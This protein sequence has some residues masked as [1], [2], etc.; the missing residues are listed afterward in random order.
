MLRPEGNKEKKEGGRWRGR[1]GRK[2]GFDFLTP[3]VI[4]DSI[5][6]GQKRR[7]YLWVSQVTVSAERGK[8]EATGKFA[9]FSVTFSAF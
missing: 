1:K 3:K 8:E 5:M 4:R 9:S 2:Q 6:P 7:F